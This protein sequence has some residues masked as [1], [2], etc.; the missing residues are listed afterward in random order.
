MTT[1]PLRRVG[2]FGPVLERVLHDE[3]ERSKPRLLRQING[4]RAGG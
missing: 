2:L 4:D 1:P 3:I